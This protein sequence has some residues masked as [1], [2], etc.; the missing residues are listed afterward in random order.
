MASYVTI[1]GNFVDPIVVDNAGSIKYTIYV[2]GPLEYNLNNS[3]IKTLLMNNITS[4]YSFRVLKNASYY[5][6]ITS[7]YKN[8]KSSIDFNI[9]IPSEID[10]GTYELDQFVTTNFNPVIQNDDIEYAKFLYN[11]EEYQLGFEGDT[12]R[13][14]NILTDESIKLF[15]MG[16]GGL[17][18]NNSFEYDLVDEDYTFETLDLSGTASVTVSYDTDIPSNALDDEIPISEDSRSIKFVIGNDGDVSSD[19]ILKQKLLPKLILPLTD[20]RLRFYFK[21]VSG[22]VLNDISITIE[23]TNGTLVDFGTLSIDDTNTGW[24]IIDIIATSDSDEY[25]INSSMETYLKI[26]MG[27]IG[28]LTLKMDEFK[29]NMHGIIGSGVGDIELYT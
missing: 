16:V 8:N 20:Y 7:E 29:L 1:T 12:F 15:E 17:L 14:K 4:T 25:L 22:T 2:K 23:N 21:Y 19:I 3:P 28:N 6:K 18:N 5:V 13:V 24:K 27:G 9:Y 10:D 26:K 11:D